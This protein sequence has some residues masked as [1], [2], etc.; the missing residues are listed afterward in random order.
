M[1]LA[2]ATKL[3]KTRPIGLEMGTIATRWWRTSMVVPLT[4]KKNVII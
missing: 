1:F 4:Q 2:Y 3:K